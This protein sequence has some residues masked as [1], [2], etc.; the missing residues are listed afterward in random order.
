[1][2]KVT[3]A[4]GFLGVALL[5]AVP[6]LW[7]CGDK[8]LVIG[9]GVRSQRTRGAVQHAAILA[10]Q[11]SAGRLQA[12]M[13][14]P[15][16]EKDLRMAGHTLRPIAS[17]AELREALRFGRYDIVLVDISEI[18]GLETELTGAPG[19]PFLL[20]MIY[21]ATGEELAEAQVQYEC[22]MKSPSTRKDYLAVIDEA[23][24][25]R[26]KQEKARGAR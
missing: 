15:N 23:M 14:E 20:P 25:Q 9:R 22:V 8:F 2:R 12:A 18:G 11:D 7:A 3:P 10:Y 24:T 19:Q 6:E 1:M 17:A 21:N 26:K 13:R 16:L 4:V 5:L